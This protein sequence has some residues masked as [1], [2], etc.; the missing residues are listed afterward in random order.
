[1]PERAARRNP[2]AVNAEQLEARLLLSSTWVVTSTADDGSSGTLRFAVDHSSAGDTIQFDPSLFSP[3]NQTAIQVLNTP[4]EINHDLSI[5]GPGLEQLNVESGF[6]VDGSAHAAISGLDIAPGLITVSSGSTLDLTDSGVSFARSNFNVVSNAGALNITRCTFASNLTSGSVGAIYNTGTLSVVDSTFSYNSIFASGQSDSGGA[7]TNAATG[8]ADIV[9]SSFSNNAAVSG[10]AIGNF[11]T[12]TISGCTLDYNISS[13]TY[14]WTPGP[15]GGAAVYSEGVLDLVNSTLYWNSAYNGSGAGIYVT[16]QATLTNSTIAENFALGGSGV[17]VQDPAA[18]TI[19]NT[20]VASNWISP[21]GAPSQNYSDIAGNVT[22]SF[23]LIGT[24]GSGGLTHGTDGN[25]VGVGDPGLAPIF[26]NGGPAQTMALKS[27]SPAF[28]AGSN[29]L[30]VDAQDQP[31]A[32]DQRGRPRLAGNAVDIGA[33]EA[34]SPVAPSSVVAVAGADEVDLS[35]AADPDAATYNVYRTTSPADASPTLLAGGI[36]VRGWLDTGVTA[37]VTYYYSV[38]AVNAAGQSAPSQMA[39]AQPFLPVIN[40]T[41]GDDSIR[42]FPDGDQLHIDWTMGAQKGKVLINDPNGLTINGNG[43]SDTIGVIYNGGYS[44]PIRI[45]F[46]GTFTIAGRG[47][48]FPLPGQVWNINRST[49]FIRYG[50]PTSDPMPS[51]LA[52]LRAGYCNGAWSGQPTDSTAVITSAAAA[53]NPSSNTAIGYADW[54]DAT[55]VNPT[56][57]TIELKYTLTGDANLDGSVNSADLQILLSNLNRTG[58]W[59]QGDFNYD[60]N[61]NSADLQALLAALNRHLGT[62]AAAAAYAASATAPTQT[63]RHDNPASPWPRTGD[64]SPAAT[65]KP[66]SAALR[67]SHLRKLRNGRSGSA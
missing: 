59:D 2:K 21:I 15:H 64:V 39:A 11:G 26:N 31:L 23:N 14:S 52:A 17:D 32:S 5:L 7:I 51:V 53:N 37:G 47:V 18:V 42:L 27:G 36:T 9:D 46:N 29:A 13:Q 65:P 63:P 54:N 50:D 43:A 20:I 4:L 60:G 34:Q 16:G 62:Q 1:M 66:T 44:L 40:G 61:V 28:D 33:Y 49:I 19:N 48:F 55:N 24:G 58:P 67:P 12:M 45:N 25:I 56:P 38:T 22:G 8:S 57:D 41:P 35:W 30:A 10:G 3:S 6:L